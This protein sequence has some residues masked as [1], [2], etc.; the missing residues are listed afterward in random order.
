MTEAA[1][2]AVL[3]KLAEVYVTRDAADLRALF[4]PDA[5]IVMYSPGDAKSIGAPAIQAKA[6]LD[7]SKSESAAL[8]F[9]WMSVSAAGP[10][11]WAAADADFTV[12]AAGQ[13]K[14]LPVRITFVL[15]QRGDQWLI[16]HAHYSIAAGAPAKG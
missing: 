13:E 3:D 7:W 14:T 9:G 2:K 5:D 12:R 8:K 10:V 15:E 4:A 6:E 11:A 1:V 16:V